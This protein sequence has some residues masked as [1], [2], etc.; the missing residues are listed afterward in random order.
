MEVGAFGEY[1]R[2][3]GGHV[4]RA[5]HAEAGLTQVEAKHAFGGDVTGRRTSRWTPACRA[6]HTAFML[7]SGA[8]GLFGVSSQRSVT[9]RKA[10]GLLQYPP[11]QECGDGRREQR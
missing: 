10:G 4:T 6:A 8:C 5:D 9:P 2:G 11:A 3:E 1:R 7:Y